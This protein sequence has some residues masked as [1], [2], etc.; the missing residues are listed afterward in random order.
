MSRFSRAYEGALKVAGLQQADVAAIAGYHT[1][2]VSRLLNSRSALTPK[3][4]SKLLLAISDPADQHHCLAEFLKD[5]CPEDFREA[6]IITMAQANE[7]RAKGA[8]PLTTDLARLERMGVDNEDLREL[9][10]LL[11]SLLS[12]K[13][14]HNSE[15]AA[16]ED[17]LSRAETRTDPIP[18]GPKPTAS[19]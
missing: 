9:I 2:M 11:V 10:S 18:R 15:L 17:I 13:L 5:C 12:Q 1:S 8:D 4:V 14:E 6:I 3:H 7:A 19:K 16:V